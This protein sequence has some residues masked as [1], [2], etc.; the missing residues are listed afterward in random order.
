M[1]TKLAMIAL[2]SFAVSAVCLGGAFALGGGQLGDAAFN[3]GDIGDGFGLPRCEAVGTPATTSETRSVPWDGSSD[4]AAIAIPANT[5]YQA[6][7]GDQLVVKGDPAIISHIRVH[8]G[9]V[10]LDCRNGFMNWGRDNRVDVTLPGRRTFQKFEM[11]GSG[12]MQLSG[13]SQP[14][15]K[16]EIDGS[17]TIETDGKVDKLNLEIDGSGTVQSKGQTDDVR[18][19]VNGSGNVRLGDLVD[20]DAHVDISGSGKV[21]IAPQ[22]SL[23]VDISGSGTIYLRSEPKSIESD[24]SGSGKIVHPNGTVED[25][26]E[27]HAEL[28]RR[29]RHHAGYTGSE[30]NGDEI[31]A[32]VQ[33]AVRNGHAPDPDKL[34]A[35]EDKLNA[36]IRDKVAKELDKVNLDDDDR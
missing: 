4:R 33:E 20:K 30:V 35:A 25:R 19:D 27:R 32:I 21:E 36:K 34:Q 23:N 11:M 17:G 31:N 9:V 1:R 8:N 28:E 6:G 2:S 16:V 24:F 10:S 3:F 18:V 22:N 13:L 5:H 14:E 15:A 26:H 12:D 7:Q 29:Y